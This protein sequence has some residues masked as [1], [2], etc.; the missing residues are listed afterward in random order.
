M[1]HQIFQASGPKPAKK[2]LFGTSLL[3]LG[4]LALHTPTHAQDAPEI[5][6]SLKKLLGGLPI[7]GIK[8]E[9]QGMVKTL[10]KTNCGNKLTGCYMTQSGPLQLYFF[11]SGT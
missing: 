3:L 11:T 6:P 7:T 5:T 1:P 8:D 9:L 2:R 4:T 10:K